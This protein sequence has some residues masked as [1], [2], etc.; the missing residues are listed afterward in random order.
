MFRSHRTHRPLRMA[1]ALAAGLGLLLSSSVASA[2]DDHRGKRRY[3]VVVHDD[4]CRD[5]HDHRDHYDRRDRRDRHDRYDR[6]HRGDRHDRYE[7][8]HRH[9]RHRRAEHR[10]YRRERFRCEPCGHG[11]HSRHKFHRHLSH[12]HRIPFWALP[13]VVV[14]STIGWVFYG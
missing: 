10:E 6:R 9:E 14:H 5:R 7:R 12:Q 13:F 2:G 3:K 11:F 4:A 8:R 1:L